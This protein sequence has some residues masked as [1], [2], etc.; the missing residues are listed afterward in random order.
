MSWMSLTPSDK[1]LAIEVMG[2]M[3]CDSSLVFSLSM[4][5]VWES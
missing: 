3:F 2:G 1:S 4:G 5:I